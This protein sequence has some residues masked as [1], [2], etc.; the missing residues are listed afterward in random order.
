MSDILCVTN[1]HLCKEDFLTRIEQIAAAQPAGIILREKDLDETAY[2]HLAAEVMQICKRQNVPCIL[3][4][5]VSVAAALQADAIHLPLPLLR[6]LSAEEKAGF[7]TLGASCHS[8]EEAIQAE[9][10]GCTYITVG[11]IFATDC[12]KGLPGRGPDCLQA[13]CDHVSI[14]VYAIGGINAPRMAEVRR[15]GA[16]GGCVMSG[17]MECDDVGQYLGEFL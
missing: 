6:G 12:K 16:A 3:H 4:T 13:V 2:Q 1:R 15:C 7:A 14:P 10:E 11:H 9:Q 5:F 17:A 8:V